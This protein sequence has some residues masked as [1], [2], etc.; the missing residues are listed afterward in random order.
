MLRSIGTC[1]GKRVVVGHGINK[2]GAAAIACQLAAIR[3]ARRRQLNLE[4]KS[5]R[6]MIEK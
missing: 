1:K 3:N 6:E 2:D 4:N 5:K